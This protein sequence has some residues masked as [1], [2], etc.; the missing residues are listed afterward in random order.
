MSESTGFRCFGALLLAAAVIFGG[1]GRVAHAGLVSVD[2]RDVAEFSAGEF[3]AARAALEA[4]GKPGETLFGVELADEPRWIDGGT[5]VRFT[6]V[7]LVKTRAGIVS[8][9]TELKWTVSDGIVD[10]RLVD[11]VP[12]NKLDFTIRVSLLQ[13]KLILEDR[14]GRIRKIYPLAVGGFD[15]GVSEGNRGKTVLV[16]P[17]YGNASVNANT[18]IE[19]QNHPAYYMNLPFI[20]ISRRDRWV[21]P[22]AFHISIDNPDGELLRKARDPKTGRI[23]EKA[24]PSFRA[25]S[26]HGCMRLRRKD[27]LELYQIVM[28]NKSRAIAVDVAMTQ[29]D[30]DDHPFPLNDSAYEAV[31]DCA[32]KGSRSRSC[33]DGHGLVLMRPVHRAPPIDAAVPDVDGS[34][35]KERRSPRA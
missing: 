29:P 7:A 12:L 16:T 19:H 9:K 34:A 28:G 15:E 20:P 2:L 13:R 11:E 6:T 5:N 32:S 30:S 33:Q 18:A 22:V 35:P 1:A 17:A 4:L 24:R 8:R 14:S 23:V 27:L 10:A 21:S 31:V 3:P 25:F 26:S